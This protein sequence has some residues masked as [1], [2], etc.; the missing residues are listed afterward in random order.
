M[1]RVRSC[2]VKDRLDFLIIV[3]EVYHTYTVHTNES[4]NVNMIVLEIT[5]LKFACIHMHY[6]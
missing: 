6:H 3:S 1:Q 5:K 2:T 4:G